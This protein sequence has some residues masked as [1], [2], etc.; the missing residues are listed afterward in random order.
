MPLKFT[1]PLL[2]ETSVLLGDVLTF[3][4]PADSL[5]SSHF[6]RNPTLGR[7]QRAF[8]A[9]SIFGVLR[10]LRSLQW[11]SP[12]AS[13]RLLL[14]LWL[15]KISGMS[16][17]ELEPA[18]K[19]GEGE[20]LA[21][22]KAAAPSAPPLAV[23]AEWPD[24]VVDALH[25]QRSAERILELGRAMQNPAALD[26]RVNTLKSSREAVLAELEKLGLKATPT[27][28]SPTGIRLTGH[29]DLARLS[30]FKSGAIEVQ[31]EGSQLIPV[32]LGA[33]RGEMVADLCAGAGGKT[34]ALGALMASSGRL[35]A[36]DVNEKRLAKLSPRLKRSGLSNVTPQ[37]ITSEQDSRLKRLAAKLDRVLVDAPCSGLGT[38]RRNPDLKYR[39]SPDSVD[40][41]NRKQ[42]S[43]IRA[44]ARLLKPGGRLVYA[45]CSLLWAENQAIVEDFLN[46]HP[47]FRLLPA[48]ELLASQRIP[49]TM[50]EYLEMDPVRH[51][52]DGFFAAILEKQR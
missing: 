43:L 9:D 50:G 32:L 8:M 39:H 44:A 37:L 17:R 31:D 47:E 4:A 41:L 6:R 40:E 42:A 21:G 29:P 27:P 19:K 45:T 14:L 18:M 16:I 35:Y 28:Y 52:T 7:D 3:A 34:L 5:L 26:L 38:V 36:F 11:Q 25:T 12:N 2:R 20:T 48:G 30:L 24:W 23:R 49:L 15:V 10:H 33:R 46:E 51:H 1:P 22:L 13:P